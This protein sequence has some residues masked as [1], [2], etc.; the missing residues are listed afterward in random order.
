MTMTLFGS[1]LAPEY[2]SWLWQGFLITIG[3]SLLVCVL[4]TLLG[5]IT[6][7][8]RMSSYRTVRWLTQSY[9][10]LF[11][12]TPLLIQLFFWYFAAPS[13]FPESWMM[14]LNMPHDI[15]FG[16][17]SVSWPSFEF[18]AGF[19]GL[20]LYTT[21][22]IAEEFRAGIQGVAV[23]QKLAGDA[24]GFTDNQVWRYIV[25]PQAIRHVFFP[26]VGQYMNTIKNTSLTMAIG[27]AELSYA[28]RQVETETFK[29]FQA[30]GIATLLYMAFIIVIEVI[31]HWIAQSKAFQYHKKVST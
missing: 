28:S 14:W 3:L 17:F 1:L 20:T 15:E 9:I 13:L 16:F 21:A 25:L 4:A 22:F 10:S 23:G 27:L 7:V 11:C 19:I 12:N 18:I 26:L 29:T 6:A 8:L 24:L 2:L 30:F 31:A 5:L